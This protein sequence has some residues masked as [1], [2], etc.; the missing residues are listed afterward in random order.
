M[1]LSRTRIKGDYPSKAK[2]IILRHMKNKVR[3]SIPI[4]I[5]IALFVIIAVFLVVGSLKDVDVSHKLFNP[6][7][8]FGKIFETFG[9][10]FGHGLVVIGGVAV[11]SGTFF[12][13][14]ILFKIIGIAILVVAF[15]VATYLFADAIGT[16]GKDPK[17]YGYRFDKSW[18]ALLVS[19]ALMALVALLGF[20][21]IDMKK[22][23][24]ALRVGII[25]LAAAIIQVLIINLLK[26]MGGRPRYR[27]LLDTEWNDGTHY[28]VVYEFKNW[29]Q[30]AFWKNPSNDFFKSWPSG[31]SGFAASF[32]AIAYLPNM[33]RRRFKFDNYVF[34]GIGLLYLI[35]MMIARIIIG[36]H[37]LSDV[38]MGALIGTFAAFISSF[39]VEKIQVFPWEKKK[40]EAPAEIPETNE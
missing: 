21:I 35:L 28:G 29:Y 18:M 17:F 37:F 13:K 36:A 16:F 31:H 10:F 14:H 26:G 33:M 8:K 3:H 4:Y 34:F 7:N 2:T 15:G 30:F 11:F 22:Q 27:F 39:V 32:L 19:A 6:E 9:L 12:R 40:E 20:F 25:I 5:Y 24:E 38:S 23:D 1:R